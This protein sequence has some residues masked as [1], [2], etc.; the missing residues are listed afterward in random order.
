MIRKIWPVAVSIIFLI[1]LRVVY[2]ELSHIH[3]RDVAAALDALSS[4]RIA[5]ALLCTAGS[6]L[7]MTLGELLATRYASSRVGYHRVSLAS[8]IGS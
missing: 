6:Y 5:L 8:F 4:T 1:A 7:A 3:L 2:V